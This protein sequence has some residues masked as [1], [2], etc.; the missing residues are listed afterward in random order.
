MQKYK[1]ETI[2]GTENFVQK[3][4]SDKFS[5]IN[6]IS[7]KPGEIDFES[8]NEINSFKNLLS[9]L[10]ITNEKGV[11]RN[12]FR[13]EWRKDF[14]P[15]GINPALAYVMCMMA[16]IKNEETISDPF[17]GGGTI[18][19]TVSLYFDTKKVIASDISGKAVNITK[20]NF[21][22]AKISKEKYFV[23][24]KGVRDLK[25]QKES[26]DKII[27]NLPF[28]IRAGTHDMNEITYLN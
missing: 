7:K 15:A 12:L 14:V 22:E 5:D 13:R 4:L 24:Q 27:S 17:C 10:R 20:K 16:D 28:G 8:D 19:I 21:E 26:I 6:I 3:E 23:L 25:F 11:T 9:A 18:P 1:L 2:K